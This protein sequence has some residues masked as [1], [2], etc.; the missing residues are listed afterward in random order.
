VKK[1]LPTIGNSRID[2]LFH[3]YHGFV[4]M[5]NLKCTDNIYIKFYMRAVYNIETGF[6]LL[7][8]FP[9]IMLVLYILYV[10][11]IHIGA[12]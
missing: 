4:L 5:I 3:A 1:N 2:E 8:L 6:I 10:Y 12:D 7:L 9:K 11:L